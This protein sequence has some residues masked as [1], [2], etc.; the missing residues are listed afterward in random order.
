MNL[1]TRK[2]WVG[3]SGFSYP[4]WVGTFY[5]PGTRPGAM[6]PYYARRFSIVELNFSFYR[7]PSP[8]AFEHM[9][10]RTPPGF[11]FLVKMSSDVTHALQLGC[12]RQFLDAVEP[13]R[14][15]GRFAGVLCQFPQSFHCTRVTSSYLRQLAGRLRGYPSF[16]EFRHRSWDRK[17]LVREMAAL[18][19][20]IVSVDVPA[21][22]SLF[23]RR[24]FAVG[25]TVYVRFHSRRAALW[26]ADG[27][28]R[29]DYS[30]GEEEL[31]NWLEDIQQLMTE[32]ERIYL[33]FNNCRKAQA[34][35]NA[36]QVKRIIDR[37]LRSD[38]IE[39]TTRTTTLV[40]TTFTSLSDYRTEAS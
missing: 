13:L 35:H 17:E 19:L 30:Y 40:D 8:G 12:L 39:K 16:I 28:D 14:N 27:K 32:T 33:L 25:G 38:D 7:M 18:Q 37:R 20:G 22:P 5:P 6:L 21:I 2:C 24:L 23:P 26:Y 10:K 1:E 36:A 31:E 34:A 29:Y 9:I 3:T 4:D 11:Q 15:A